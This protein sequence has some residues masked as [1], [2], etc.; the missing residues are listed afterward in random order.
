MREKLRDLSKNYDKSE[1]DLKAL[2][3]VGQVSSS[4]STIHCSHKLFFKKKKNV[5]IWLQNVTDIADSTIGL[6]IEGELTCKK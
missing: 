2:Q 3:S 6:C 4:L 1:N 5:T